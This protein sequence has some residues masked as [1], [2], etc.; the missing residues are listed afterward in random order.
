M[1]RCHE[2]ARVVVDQ[3]HEDGVGGMASFDVITSLLVELGLYSFEQGAIEEFR[4]LAGQ[5]LTLV[6]GFADVEAKEVGVVPKKLKAARQ[7]AS[8]PNE[9]PIMLARPMWSDIHPLSGRPT[10][11]VLFRSASFKSIETLCFLSKSANASLAYR[12]Q[13]RVREE[14]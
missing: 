11:L 2:I 9:I 4:L 8:I 14:S 5:D 6:P 13:Q 3:A 12:F 1:R 10:P 7:S